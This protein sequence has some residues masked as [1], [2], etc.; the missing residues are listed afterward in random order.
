MTETV[1]NFMEK[2]KISK[3]I[4]TIPQSNILFELKKNKSEVANEEKIILFPTAFR[5][6]KDINHVLK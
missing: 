4:Y 3:K 1:A 5:K 6:V 2:I